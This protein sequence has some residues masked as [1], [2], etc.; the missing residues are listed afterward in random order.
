MFYVYYM[1]G[2][3]DFNV[4]KLPIQHASLGKLRKSED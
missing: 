4:L 3:S 2:R 1:Y